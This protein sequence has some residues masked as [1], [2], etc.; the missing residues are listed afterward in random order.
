MSFSLSL[1]SIYALWYLASVVYG[2][3]FHC[4]GNCDKPVPRPKDAISGAAL[5]GGEMYPGVTVEQDL[6]AYR[7]LVNRSK[8]HT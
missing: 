3:S 6:N 4:I 5:C 7:W 1:F 8:G 2:N